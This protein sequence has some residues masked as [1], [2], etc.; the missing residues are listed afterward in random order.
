L[1]VLPDA[2]ALTVRRKVVAWHPVRSHAY[3]LTR[4]GCGFFFEMPEGAFYGFP[5]L[6]GVRIKVAEHTGGE[7]VA[8]PLAVDRSLR[9][10]DIERTAGF[11]REVMPDV[12]PRPSAHSVC[13]YTMTPDEHFLIDRHPAHANVVFGAG[14][15]GHGFKFTS[16]IGEAMAE[17]AADGRTE[18][19]IGFLSL[20]RFRRPG[21]L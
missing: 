2:P 21:V 6:D 17:L 19:P 9:E 12:D 13:L 3:D 20:G 5:S 1:A 4:N 11:L 7:S 15:S 16:V 10:S 14:F 18:S 8:D